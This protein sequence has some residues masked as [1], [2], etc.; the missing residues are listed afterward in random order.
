MPQTM[1]PSRRLLFTLTICAGSFLLFLVQPM[2]ARMALPRLGGAPAVWNSAMLVYQALL[3]GGYAYAH[4]LTRFSGRVQSVVHVVL[5]A[6]AALMLPIGLIA[7]DP[8]ADANPFIWVPWLFALSIGPLF[9]MIASQAPL[10]QRWFTLS[11]GAN[12]YPLYAASN[13]GSFGGLIAYPLLVEPLLPLAGQRLLWSVGYAVVLLLVSLSAWALPKD[14]IAQE[15]MQSVAP[16]RAK[17]LLYWIILA[18]VPSGLMLSTSLHL[19]TDIVAMPLL[20]VLPLGLYLLSFSV[21]FAEKRGLAKLITRAAPFILA[22]AAGCAFLNDAQRPILYAVVGLVM[23]FSVSVA[24]HGEM[25]ARRPDPQHLTRFY[26]AMS[27]GGVVGGLFGALVAPLIFN[28]GYEYP[29]LI[30]ASALLLSPVPL[31]RVMKDMRIMRILLIVTLFLSLLSGGLLWDGAPYWAKASAVPAMFAIAILMMGNRI[32]FALALVALMLGVDG[33]AKVSQSIRPGVLTRS[34]FGIYAVTDNAR[35]D[36]TLVH[37]TTIH[38]IQNRGSDV[39]E[40]MATS[41]Y[42]P[43]SGVGLAMQ[44][45]PALFGSKARIDVVGLGAG[46]LAC[47]AQRGQVWRLYEIDPAIVAIARDPK[48]F[49]FLSK[50]LP[51]APIVVGD[52]RLMIAREPAAGADIVVVDAF[53]SDSVPMHLLTKEAFATYQR[54]LSPGGL[55]MIHISNRYL[56]LEPVLAAAAKDGWSAKIREYEATPQARIDN[57]TSSNWVALA[58]DPATLYK[59]FAQQ[60]AQTWRPIVERDGFVGWTDDYGSILPIIK[61]RYVK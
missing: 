20:W 3:L 41:Y 59:L 54:R 28:W 39:R 7:T 11:G 55:L 27:V 47:Y 10:M 50:C 18:A 31:I 43:L 51:E 57:M 44:A 33:W 49:S 34:F 21:A 61:F 52:A 56:A 53:S 16:P 24:L 45:A 6:L 58:R 35:G 26:L 25:F 46:T 4:W 32:A 22:F 19:T 29:L 1:T 30:A 37:G 2:M 14:D 17:T 13:L 60:P 48:R 36:R 23:L 42:A 9:F 15:Q 12:P 8:P 40:R 5:F 38:G